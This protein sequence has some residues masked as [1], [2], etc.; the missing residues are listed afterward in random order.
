MGECLMSKENLQKIIKGVFK[1]E[2]QINALT[3]ITG[4]AQKGTYKVD[5]SDQFSCVLYIWDESLSYFKNQHTKEE[6]TS[7]SACLFKKN[8]ELLTSYN[9]RVP[10]IYHMDLSKTN[11]SFEYAL[12]QYIEGGELEQLMNTSQVDS[13]LIMGDLKDNIRKLHS[14]KS[15]RVGDLIYTREEDFSCKAYIKQSSERALRYLFENYEPMAKLKRQVIDVSNRLY[16]KIEERKEYSLIHFELGPNHVMVDKQ[17]R[18]YLIDF[19]GMKYFDLEYEYS[20]LKLRYGK[21]YPYLKS[22]FVDDNRMKYYLLHHHIM[23]VEGAHKLM[24]QD[25]YDLEDVKGMIKYNYEAILTNY[26]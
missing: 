4:G 17:G 2:Y 8:Y 21:Y 20:F 9:I 22:M 18:T 26:L 10:K 15:S 13:T 6:F 7:N 24:T 25:Y 19:E 1:K 12:V 3:R 16:A 11:F 5:C 23:A 14:I